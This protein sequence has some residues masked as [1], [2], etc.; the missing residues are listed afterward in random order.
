MLDPV[1]VAVNDVY[2]YNGSIGDRIYTAKF[3]CEDGY[4][5]NND[6]T[7]CDLIEYDVTYKLNGGDNNENNPE[8]VSKNGSTYTITV[9]N[10]VKTGFTFEGWTTN[11]AD[12]TCT[13]NGGQELEVCKSNNSTTP[14][15]VVF[16]K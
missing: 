4:Q 9:Y 12:Y 3:S 6:G 16:N 15:K 5:L 8:K 7:S 13:T 14:I 1:T 11:I 10:P 2:I